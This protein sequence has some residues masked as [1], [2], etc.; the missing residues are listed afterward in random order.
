M[1][2]LQSESI[3]ELMPALLKAQANFGP[4]V[5]N[6]TNPHFNSKFVDLAGVLEAVGP[7]LLTEGILLSQPTDFV[8]GVT[9]LR[10]RLIHQSGEWIGSVYPVA[11]GVGN[12]QAAGS[13]L[14]Y[15][16]RY[17]ALAICG[18]APEDDDGNAA[19]AAPQFKAVPL[20]VSQ[21]DLEY[22]G[23][24]FNEALAMVKKQADR[25]GWS[26]EEVERDYE[27]RYGGT[28]QGSHPSA[29]DAYASRLAAQPEQQELGAS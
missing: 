21:R 7:A 3:A 24:S 23:P 28:L 19:S 6:A 2:E 14:T 18:I 20:R 10:T 1:S 13:A 26:K 12:P 8:D 5:R 27:V 29:L 22:A 9:V 15:A 4:A 17:T 11:A 25:L 16:R